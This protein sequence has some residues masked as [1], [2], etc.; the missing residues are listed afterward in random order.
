[1]LSTQIINH[2]KSP[3]LIVQPLSGSGPTGTKRRDL[4]K[5]GPQGFSSTPGL[6][7]GPPVNLP[8]FWG[9]FP[10][11]NGYPPN[12]PIFNRGFS[13]YKTIHFCGGGK[14]PV[15]KTQKPR[16]GLSQAGPKK[17]HHGVC[18]SNFYR[19][20]KKNPREYADAHIGVCLGGNFV[21]FAG[22]VQYF[23]PIQFLFHIVLVLYFLDLRKGL[24]WIGPHD[25][26]P[27]YH[28]LLSTHYHPLKT[29]VPPFYS[30]PT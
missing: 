25:F 7:I 4:I 26:P 20:W 29:R 12:H 19:P 11:N 21:F 5:F 13:H 17:K 8:L 16:H 27:I 22:C 6:D 10:K 3:K 9:V 15:S 30:T 18:R 24:T 14:N 2:L 28:F 23:C 1:M